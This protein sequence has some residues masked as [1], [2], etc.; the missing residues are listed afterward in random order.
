MTNLP[1]PLEGYNLFA[2][3]TPLVEAFRREG[4]AGEERLVA[5]GDELGGEPLEWGRLANE[6]PPRLRTHDRFG[7]RI[8][9]VEFHPAW[10]ALMELGVEH[11]VHARPWREPA[12]G[13]HVERAVAFMLLT[14]AEAGVCCPL[15]MTHA[16]V[17][18]LRACAPAL[19][20][21]WEPGLTSYLYEPGLVP[22]D[23]EALIASL[24]SFCAGALP[25]QE[26]AEN[27]HRRPAHV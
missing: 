3:D 6:H 22:A 9:E 23:D 19:A 5:L 13:A 8:D 25:R 15:S 18:A 2:E 20:A 21:E 10:H 26:L 11:G 24:V 17:P 16:A 7:E 14:Q 1:P 27:G 12:P 4:G